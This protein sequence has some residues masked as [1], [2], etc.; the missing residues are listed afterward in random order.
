MFPHLLY[1]HFIGINS[2]PLDYPQF[3]LNGCEIMNIN[4]WY[5]SLRTSDFKAVYHDY[6]Q[7]Y[8]QYSKNNGGCSWPFK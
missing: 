5:L 1:L 3:I 7:Q 8:T 6:Y 2:I 4:A